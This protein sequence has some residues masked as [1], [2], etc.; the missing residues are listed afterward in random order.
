[1]KK[2]TPAVTPAPVETP[3]PKAPHGQ[4]APVMAQPFAPPPPYVHKK[5]KWS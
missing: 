5:P 1:M 4:V 3:K 2:T